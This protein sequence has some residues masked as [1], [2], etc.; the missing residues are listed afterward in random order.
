MPENQLP[1]GEAIVEGSLE[2]SFLAPSDLP[3]IADLCQAIEYFDDPTQHRELSGLQEDFDR[4][5]A[6][7]SN[8]AVVGR[9]KGG[10]IVAY[11]WNHITPSDDLLPHAWMEIGVHP[12]WRHHKIGVKLVEWLI[13]RA[14]AWYRHIRETHVRI[15][16]LWVGCAADEGS[17]VADDLQASG[18]LGPQRWFCDAHR[19][20]TDAPHPLVVPPA[21]VELRAFEREW[22]EKVRQAHNMAFGT[23]HGSHDVP[24]DAWQASLERTDSRPEWSWIAVPTDDR[25]AP[26][27]GYAINCEIIDAQ[28]GWREGWTER[29]GVVPA[30]QG[31]GLAHALLAASMQR[32]ADRGC[33]LAGIGIDTDNLAES[34]SLFGG[35]GYRFEDRVVLYGATFND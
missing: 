21:G 18:L 9:D 23:R 11:G 5:W 24:Q 26:V 10:T 16:P 14:R 1:W 35:M 25:D 15:G 4:P 34:E 12:A 13:D 33:V 8:H 6:Y 32:F 17:R 30:Y 2:W 28:T 22:S 29:I 3:E 19:S 7:P 20:L 31:A 27:V